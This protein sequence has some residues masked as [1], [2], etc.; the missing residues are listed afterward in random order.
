MS[1][2]H[3]ERKM[4]NDAQVQ[5]PPN[6]VVRDGDDRTNDACSVNRPVTVTRL[7]FKVKT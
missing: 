6:L 1:E 2:V 4:V 3:I 5:S 7:E